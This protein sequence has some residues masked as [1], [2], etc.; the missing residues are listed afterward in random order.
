MTHP[1]RPLALLVL[2][3]LAPAAAGCGNH[4]PTTGVVG[5]AAVSSTAAITVAAPPAPVSGHGELVALAHGGLGVV[6]DGEGE[7]RPLG[8]TARVEAAGG[9]PG[10]T[11]TLSGRVEGQAIAPEEVTLDDVAVVGRLR[12][13]NGVLVVL[14][15]DG[16]RFAPEGPL[17]SALLA[18]PLEAPLFVTGRLTAGAPLGAEGLAV[19]SWRAAVE[20]RLCDGQASRFEQYFA[21]EDVASGRYRRVEAHRAGR[22]RLSAEQ[23]AELAA[24]LAAAEAD[25]R[26]AR[27]KLP[28][29]SR[30]TRLELSDRAGSH[31]IEAAPRRSV[32]PALAALADAL[33]RWRE[34]AP[35][36]RAVRTGLDARVTTPGAAIAR[37]DAEGRDLARRTVGRSQL[38]RVRD[39]QALVVAFS[40]VVPAGRSIELRSV[41]RVGDDLYL[42]AAHGIEPIVAAGV[43]EVSPYAAVLLELAGVE[44]RVF[45]GTTLAGRVE[46]LTLTE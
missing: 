26:A 14:A 20:L 24:L 45:V 16:R 23:R 12:A 29:H 31:A 11:L 9:R 22:G 8:E 36:L 7:A 44:G 33:Q 17:A 21:V 4:P 46:G 41:E 13:E 1:A 39:G 3:S 6:F 15:N 18:E 38:H 37:T 30:Q 43:R 10:L 42:E 34:G 35:T 28:T 2:A 19:T 40:G 25:L 5:A 32:S 27:P